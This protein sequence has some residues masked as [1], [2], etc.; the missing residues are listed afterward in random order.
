MSRA[1]LGGCMPR[2]RPGGGVSR[3]RPGDCMLRARQTRLLKPIWPK[4]RFTCFFL[5]TDVTS[6]YQT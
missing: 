1:R 3:A 2:A 4:S 6:L 5:V